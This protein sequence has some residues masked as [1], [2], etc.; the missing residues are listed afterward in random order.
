MKKNASFFFYFCF[1]LLV[2]TNARGNWVRQWDHR[3]GGVDGDYVVS[4]DRTSRQGYVLAGKTSSDSTGNKTTHLFGNGVFDYW[5]IRLDSLGNLVWEK[6]IRGSGN[7]AL[8]SIKSTSDGGF[9]IGGTSDS[10]FGGDKTHASYGGT[11]YWVLKL[12]SLG[13]IQ[14]DNVYGGSD[15][16]D[17]WTVMETSDGGFLIGGDSRSGI[18]GNKTQGTFGVNDFW[19]V[20]VNPQGIKTWDKVFGGTG[21]EQYRASVETAGHQYIIAG[22]SNSGVGGNRTDVSQGGMDYWMLQIDSTGAILWDSAYGGLGD[23]NLQSVT[24]TPGGGM[25]VGGWTTTDVSGDKTQPTNGGYDFWILKLNSVGAIQWDKDFGGVGL[26]DEFNCITPSYDGGFYLGATSYSNAGGDKTD[27]NLGVEQPWIIKM[28]SMG[29][30]LWDKTVFTMGHNENGFVHETQD[31]KCFVVVS[32]DNGVI[33]GDK[34]EDAWGG[35]SSDYWIVKYCQGKTND[36]NE[37][38]FTENDLMV[39]PNPFAAEVS[40]QLNPDAMISNSSF[41]LFDVIGQQILSAAFT[42]KITLN[43]SLLS[44]GI[45]FLEVIADGK[46]VRKKILKY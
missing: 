35:F 18:S 8:W 23:D 33:G 43:T 3:Y 7:D 39:Y 29:N 20:K 4:S 2:S 22:S 46:K 37:N 36:I 19:I 10:P 42:N 26:E 27:D 11:D 15:D 13:N 12:D 6:D 1:C 21:Y 17:L 40:V 31:H 30:K 25:L 16:E 28:D 41:A 14:W 32:G 34:T 9:I 24:L 38:S 45:Y 44:K 5:I